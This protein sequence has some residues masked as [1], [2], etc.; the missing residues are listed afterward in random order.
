[1]GKLSVEMAEKEYSKRFQEWQDA[2]KEYERIGKQYIRFEPVIDGQP[3]SMPE[4]VLDADG[5]RILG[6]AAEKLDKAKKAF[7]EASV[8]LYKAY[9]K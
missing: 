1:M 2:D 7:D 5:F 4:K 8:K 3:L 6:Q 9:K